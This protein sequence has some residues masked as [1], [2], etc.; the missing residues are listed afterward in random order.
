MPR[1]ITR[2]RARAAPS[3]QLRKAVERAFRDEQLREIEQ[4]VVLAGGERSPFANDL[5]RLAERLGDK[6]QVDEMAG[7]YEFTG[8]T[9]MTIPQALEVKE[10]LEKIDELLKQLDEAA[11][12]AQIGL[13]DMEELSEFA[14][15]GDIE[16]LDDLQQQIQD[17]LRD[18]A[19]QQGLEQTGRGFQLTPEGVSAVPR[20]SCC[21]R[22]FS[23]LAGVA[24]R[25]ASGADRRRR[26]GRAAADE[27]LRVRRF[28]RATWIFP[29]SLI[30]AMLRGGPACRCGSSRKTSKSTARATR[31]SAPP[32]CCWT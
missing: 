19:E 31:P 23:E 10:E 21:T 6:Y 3:K 8:H 12:T 28:G 7:K 17:Y 9:P 15:P 5:L 13:I 30:N 16:Q 32:W 11:K 20:R 25:P 14:E 22:I 29:A 26:S 2:T 18:M 4:S 27:A 24:H 1:N